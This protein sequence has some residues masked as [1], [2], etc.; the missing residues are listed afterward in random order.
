MQRYRFLALLSVALLPATLGLAQSENAI[1]CAKNE[2]FAAMIHG[3]A[4]DWELKE[5]NAKAYEKVMH[6]VIKQMHAELKAGASAMQVVTNAIIQLEDSPLLNAG[7]GA[8]ANR[9]G[10]HELDAS[11]MD[12]QNLKAG[13][14]AAVSKIKNPILAAKA[15]MEHSPYVFLVGEGAEQF[16]KEQK[17]EFVKPEYFQLKNKEAS[18]RVLEADKKFGTVGAVVLDRCGNL[19]AGTST[20]GY[21]NKMPGRVGDAPII[22]AGTYADNRS[23]AVSATG[24]GEYF[25][26]YAVA[27]DISARMRYQEIS[28]KD[29]ADA[30]IKD[31]LVKAGGSGG[32]IAVDKHGQT[33]ASYNSKAMLHASVNHNGKVEV[34]FRYFVLRAT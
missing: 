5:K 28:L 17:I 1:T 20:G 19:A 25:I 12:G 21:Q 9:A 2:S 32:I 22:G 33:Y 23:V 15:V 4:G 8:I 34:R 26:R 10:Q 11:I 14:V 29:A 6:T 7:R 27:H 24:H 31:E 30:V 3:G 18:L 13:A 16:A